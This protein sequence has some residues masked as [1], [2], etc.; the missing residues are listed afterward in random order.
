[1]KDGLIIGIVSGWLLGVIYL[2]IVLVQNKLETK[3]KKHE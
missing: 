1:M 2:I 3:N